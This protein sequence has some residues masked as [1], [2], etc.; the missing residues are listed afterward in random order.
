MSGLNEILLVGA[1][2]AF[3]AAMATLLLI[4]RRDF[5]ESGE[6]EAEALT[7]EPEVSPVAP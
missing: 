6:G 3:A 1:C 7:S 4:R 2:V 5:V